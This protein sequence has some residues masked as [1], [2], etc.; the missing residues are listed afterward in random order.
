MTK[1]LT[2]Q[3]LESLVFLLKGNKHALKLVLDMLWVGHLWDD[4][5]DGDVPRSPE[6]INAAFIK[7]FR[8]IPNNPFFVGLPER[9]RF[10]L[11]G[12]LISAAMQYRDATQL[13]MGDQGDR[14]VAFIIRNAVLAFIHYL[15]ALV[16]GDEWIKEHGPDFWRFF[17]TRD[18]Y[19]EFVEEGVPER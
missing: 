8:E 13:E 10:Q 15:I 4:L 3:E 18:N 14:F 7:A 5:I 16:G 9:S 11:E 17:G 6:D 12:L 2:E 1:P 19:K